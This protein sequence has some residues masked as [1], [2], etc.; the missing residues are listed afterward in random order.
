MKV[1]I[2]VGNKGHWE[3]FVSW[4]EAMFLDKEKAEAFKSMMNEAYDSSE[5]IPDAE[6]IVYAIDERIGDLH[7]AG[8]LE[9]PEYVKDDSE[10]TRKNNE[11]YEAKV[12]EISLKFLKQFNPAY[13]IDTLR[14]LQNWDNMRYEDVQFYI[15]EHELKDEYTIEQLKKEHNG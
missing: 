3:D 1:Y 5:P 6:N 2:V 9:Y 8:E 10:Q 7:D 11:E 15:E 13:T 14:R 4:N 12:N